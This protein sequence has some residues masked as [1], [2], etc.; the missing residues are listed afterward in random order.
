MRKQQGYL[1][2]LALIVSAQLAGAG[3]TGAAD[4]EREVADT[5]REQSELADSLPEPDA[6]DAELEPATDV[7]EKLWRGEPVD[8]RRVVQ[9]QFPSPAKGCSAVVIGTFTNPDGTVFT[10]LLTSAHC[11]SAEQ[12]GTWIYVVVAR[13][14]GA[15]RWRTIGVPPAFVVRHPAYGGKG[16]V[17]DDIALVRLWQFPSEQVQFSRLY[18]GAVRKSNRLYTLGWGPSSQYLPGGTVLRTDYQFAY[19]QPDW[20]GAYHFFDDNDGQTNL[21]HG[22]SGGPA[23]LSTLSMTVVA[24]LASNARMKANRYCR[25]SQGGYRQSWTRISAKMSW[26]EAQRGAPCR[27]IGGGLLAECW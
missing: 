9:V 6:T 7:E 12:D 22:D 10:D 4:D 24:G 21:C 20:I 17:A 27:R 14:D 3:C 19:F 15:G 2:R 13:S 1:F 5:A 16:D 25:T 23:M 18:L 8:D 26:I 11:P